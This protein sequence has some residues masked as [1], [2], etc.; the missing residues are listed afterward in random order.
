VDGSTSTMT[1]AQ[2]QAFVGIVMAIYGIVFLVVTALF[3][4]LFWRIFVK[5]GMSGPIALLNIIPGVGFWICIFI[6]AFSTWPI[7]AGRT[8][9]LGYQPQPPPQQPPGPPIGGPPMNV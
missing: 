3:V 8:P 6:L 9:Q 1:T 2:T 7:E 4:W 5:A